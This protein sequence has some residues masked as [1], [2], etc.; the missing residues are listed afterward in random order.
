MKRKILSLLLALTLVLG[1]TP[2]VSAATQ[3]TAEDKAEVL[4]KLDL[5]HGVSTMEFE[6]NLDGS[7]NREQAVKMVV[8]AL[9]WVIDEVAVTKFTDV[10]DWAQ[11]YVASAVKNGVTNG[12]GKDIEGNE[13]FGAADVITARQLETWF[14]R[15]ITQSSTAW[16]D[17]IKLNN[18]QAVDRAYL[19]AST[20]DA[21]KN[22]PVNASKTLIETVIG[23]DKTLIKIATDGGLIEPEGS[24]DSNEPTIVAIDLLDDDEIVITFSE[25]VEEDSA[26]EEDNYVLYQ[27]DEVEDAFDDIELTS[28][29]KVTI[30]FEDKL[31]GE[32]VIVIKNVED[33]SGNKISDYKVFNDG[34]DGTIIKKIDVEDDNEIVVTFTADVDED[35]AEDE[36][37][38]T[39]YD[40]DDDELPNVIRSIELTDDDEITIVFE[41]DLSGKHTLEIDGVEDEFE[42]DIED[43]ASFIVGQ[44]AMSIKDIDIIDD[45][46]IVVTFSEDLDE[47]SA[48]DEDNYTILDD[49]N[50]EVSNI[51][52][53]IVLTDDDEVTIIFVEDL[54][55]DYTLEVDGVENEDGDDFEDEMDFDFDDN[56]SVS[57]SRIDVIDEDEIQ[58]TFT[59]DIDETTAERSSNYTLYDEDQDEVEDIFDTISL[60]DDDEVTI[61]FTENLEGDYTLE[62]NGVEDED[63]DEVDDEED[64]EVDDAKV[65]IEDVDISDDDEIILTFTGDVDKATAEDEDNYVLYDDDGD[66]IDNAIR[67]ID[68]TDDDEVTIQFEDDLSGEYTLEVDGVEDENGVDIE[69]DIDFD[70][71]S[72][73]NDAPSIKDIDIESTMIIVVTFTEDVDDRTAEK[74]IYYTLF[75]DDNVEVEDVI[76]DV[77]VTD[78]DEVTILFSEELSGLYKLEVDGVEDEAGNDMDDSERFEVNID[79]DAPKIDEIDVIDPDLIIVTFSEDVD[80][81]SAE[82]DNNY[83]IL[84]DDGDEVD[85]IIDRVVQSDDD[86][87]RIYFDEDLD[88]GYYTLVIVDVEDEA[89]NQMDDEDEFRIR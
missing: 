58:V 60:S 73:D 89:G 83:T 13:L 23:T 6:P 69:D 61:I 31:S 63:G 67:D 72:N 38:Y 87:I 27:G 64:F 7:A 24:E 2:E 8:V 84:D 3:L 70:T 44:A 40:D 48:E 57:I 88:N 28:N 14:D 80:E 9:G 21:L 56:S 45:D 5:F 54:S 29:N 11:P 16:E 49:D 82:E 71:D 81:D 85:I 30:K 36:D 43:E 12:I 1:V 66:E 19:V 68:L 34:N 4:H 47:D 65:S 79:E 22:K 17:N 26:E 74:V 59:G 42:D 53:T 62:I 78:S 76:S 55:G 86:E 77:G 20:Y 32:Y 41:V 37:Y 50:D 51:I 39:V 46:E 33:L 15:V 75:D 18:T 52:D 25:A 35:S 10:S